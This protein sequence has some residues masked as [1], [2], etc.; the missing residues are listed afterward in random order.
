MRV[1]AN[2]RS[3]ST[4]PRE[5]G[6]YLSGLW[7]ISE[8]PR[9][10]GCVRPV[11]IAPVM[12]DTSPMIGNARPF[13]HAPAG[14]RD[15]VPAI[16]LASASAARRR[17]LAAA[18]LA[19]A[20]DPADIDEGATKARLLSAGA[21]P[22]EVALALAREKAEAVAA[23]RPDDLVVAAD[24][25]L[26]LGDRLFDK[27]RD[28]AEAAD[29]LRALRGRRHA[30]W[31]AAVLRRGDAILWEGVEPAHLAMRDLSDAFLE[32]YLAAAGESVLSSVGAY[33]LEGL[34]AHLF[35]GVEG[36]HFT[37]Q[38]LPLFALLD[39]L[40]AAGALRA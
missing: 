36:D 24:Q 17:L 39:A 25:V 22:P 21:A 5:F 32:S 31:S 3:A 20:V 23:R 4:L 34:G 18:G 2:R 9:A 35:A 6:L 13:P 26:A 27:P 29:H 1:A 28:M 40:R 16:V 10:H 37:V 11:V 30:L 15:P 14:G 8:R 12:A 7:R 19:F 33:A 38:G